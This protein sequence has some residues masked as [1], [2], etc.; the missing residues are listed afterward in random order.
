L[1]IK[2]TQLAEAINLRGLKEKLS[3]KKPTKEESPGSTLPILEE[4]PT[5]STEVEPSVPMEV[6]EVPAQEPEVV[7]EPVVPA[8]EETPV[9]P[10]EVPPLPEVKKVIIEEPKVE[11]K[12]EE[13]KKEKPP[14]PFLSALRSNPEKLGPVLDKKLPPKPEKRAPQKFEKKGETENKHPPR[15]EPREKKGPSGSADPIPQKAISEEAPHRAG[16]KWAV[17]GKNDEHPDTS[18]QGRKFKGKGGDQK[19]QRKGIETKIRQGIDS[20]DDEGTGWRRRRHKAYRPVVEQEVQRPTN[21]SVRLP[22]SVK[23]LAAAMKLKASQLISTLFLQGTVVTLN[24]E[25]SDET[26]VQLLGHE[27]GC[28]VTIDTKEAERLQVTGQSVLEEITSS[29]STELVKRPPVVAFM[30]HVDHGKTSLIDAIRKSNRV[31]SEVGAITQHIGAFRCE[32]HNGTITIIDTPGHEAFSAMRERGVGVTDVVV[33]VIAGDEGI[34]E[35]TVE[36]LKQ[37]KEG[38]VTILVAVNKCDKPNYDIDRVYRQLADQ[39]LL[40]EAWGGH[41]VTV[42]CSALTGQGIPELLEMIALQAD[43]LELKANPN[44]RARGVVIESEM[45]KGFGPVATVLVQNG[46]LKRGDCLVFATKW[47]RVK[48]MRNESNVEVEIAPPS[49]PVRIHGLSGVPEAGEEFIVVKNEKEAKEIAEGRKEGERRLAFQ[50]KKKI[51]VE[52]MMQRAAVAKKILTLVVK[53]DV[54]GSLEAVK[55]ALLRIPSEKVEVNIISLGVGEVTESD[56][57]LAAASKAK[58]IGFHVGIE[59][60]ADLLART[61]GVSVYMHSIIYHAVDEVKEL[62]RQQLDKIAQEHEKGKAEVRAIFK[63]SQLGLIAGCQVIEGSITRN[64]TIRVRRN[65]EELWKGSVSSLKRFKD[66][67]KEVQKGTEC[68]IVLNGFSDFAEHDILEAFEVVYVEPEL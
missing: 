13:P 37:A 6:L 29:A 9:L 26:M 61:L 38:N 5:F 18:E 62:M 32:T 25:L 16:W 66:D 46:T 60:H 27:L 14:A 41:I 1:H 43:V 22:I 63:S 10:A 67:V 44:S 50:T 49:T 21:I 33:L 68:G 35:Q 36:A 57:Q 20:D 8:I 3:R 30:G 65:N 54:Q 11:K 52:N 23:D 47:A 64:C 59:T 45:T 7:P 19:L 40:P 48:S 39:S 31:Q 15:K 17:K 55:T 2:N 12:I 53:A 42:Q 56:V 51:S 4:E 28:E 24:D 34:K 58:I